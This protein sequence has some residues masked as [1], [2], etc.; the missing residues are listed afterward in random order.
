[1]GPRRRASRHRGTAPGAGGFRASVGALQECDASAGLRPSCNLRRRSRQDVG[2]QRFN[3]CRSLVLSQ[4]RSAPIRRQ[5]G[6]QTK[7]FC[8]AFR[9]VPR[10]HVQDQA[11]RGKRDRVRVS[12]S[13]S[14]HC[15]RSNDLC[16]VLSVHTTTSRSSS[17]RHVRH[18][19]RRRTAVAAVREQ[20][21]SVRFS[22]VP[23]GFCTDA[24]IERD[25]RQRR[26]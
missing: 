22:G 14:V 18:V 25:A 8:Q 5:P 16:N 19:Q 15:T 6:L 24:H 7:H 23:C 13:R 3:K 9:H 4:L 10:D 21:P 12:A 26:Q 2:G 11:G 20:E 17:R 1:M